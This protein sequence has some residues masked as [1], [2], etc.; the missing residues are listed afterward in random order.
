MNTMNNIKPD[1]GLSVITFSYL[2]VIRKV[3]GNETFIDFTAGLGTNS[4]ISIPLR[5]CKMADNSCKDT[6]RHNFMN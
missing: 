5:V 1:M 3:S 6:S 4:D 2:D